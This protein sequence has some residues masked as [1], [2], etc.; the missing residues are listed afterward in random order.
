MLCE[1]RG[2]S[3]DNCVQGESDSMWPDGNLRQTARPMHGNTAPRRSPRD[4]EDRCN[5]NAELLRDTKARPRLATEKLF[6]W[7]SGNGRGQIL[8]CPATS[9]AVVTAV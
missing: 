6:S 2:L 5:L 7:K 1:R 4:I 8:I 3:E 9:L